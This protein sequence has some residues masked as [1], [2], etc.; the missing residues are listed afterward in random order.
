MVIG[1]YKIAEQV[2]NY[3]IYG[4]IKLSC[5]ITNRHHKIEISLSEEF[6]K[7]RS[8]ILFGAEYYLEHCHMFKGLLI[9]INNIFFNAVD[10]NN[11]VI[12]YITVQALINATKINTRNNPFFD[13]NLVAFVFPK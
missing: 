2:G 6:E 9:R 1:K 5:E 8:G 11:T 7:W 3:G 10:T 4:E 13:K 12:A